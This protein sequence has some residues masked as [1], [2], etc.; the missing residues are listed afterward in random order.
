MTNSMAR[1]TRSGSVLMTVLATLGFG[2][3]SLVWMLVSS[4]EPYLEQHDSLS[5]GTWSAV[6]LAPL[7]TGALCCVPIGM[8]TDRYGARIMFPVVSLASAGAAA[9]LAIAPTVPALIAVCCALGIGG[10]AF[11]VGAAM[12]VRCGR[13]A[14]RGLMLSVFSAGIGGAAIGAA[15]AA[16][17]LDPFEVRTALLLIATAPAAYAILAAVLIRDP[18]AHRV[19]GS[20]IR[21]AFSTLRVRTTRYWAALYGIAVGGLLAMALYLPTYLHRQYHRGWRGAVL[22]TAVFVAVAALARPVGGRLAE[23]HSAVPVLTWSFAVIAALGTVQAFE[24]MQAVSSATFAGLAIALG[25]A[26]GALCDLM[27]RTVPGDQAGLITGIIGA[28]G[29]LAGLVPP[30]LLAVVEDLTHSYA[31]A[32][33]LLSDVALVAALHLGGRRDWVGEVLSYPAVHSL[34]PRLDMTA[35]TVVALSGADA[36]A[37]P[38][39]TVSALAELAIRHELVIT[40]GYTGATDA[41]GPHALIDALRARLPRFKVGAMLVDAY[42][43]PAGPAECELLL[44]LLADGVLAMA[45]VATAD[46]GPTAGALATRLGADMALRLGYDPVGGVRLRELTDST[47]TVAG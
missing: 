20:A 45:V 23:R 27:G 21:D 37:S 14:H 18:G 29:A 33:M 36:A 46:P 9:T 32:L 10:A 41:M 44:Q 19:G 15:V 30:L 35:T 12:L 6:L 38:S 3:N 28:A 24:P 47:S 17:L 16:P 43:C 7:V 25:L 13:P 31:I 8:L 1:P 2:V 34:P 22:E 26:G 42:P 4:V 11:T 5:P 40:Y 39:A